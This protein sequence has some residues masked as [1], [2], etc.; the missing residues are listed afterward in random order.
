[1]TTVAAGSFIT[2]DVP[3]STEYSN[4]GEAAFDPIF[5]N[6]WIYVAGIGVDSVVAGNGAN[7]IHGDIGGSTILVGDG[8][9]IIYAS[10]TG[11][12]FIN[13]GSLPGSDSARAGGGNDFIDVNP[14]SGGSYVVNGGGGRTLLEV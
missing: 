14:T 3:P 8:Q 11:S 1:M 5:S 12:D 4:V 7:T 9:D 10:G 2:N 13:S 6:G